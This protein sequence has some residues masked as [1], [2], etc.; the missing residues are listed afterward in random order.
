M[1]RVLFLIMLL[2][3]VLTGCNN[4][5]PT[6][7][8]RFSQYI[9][10]WNE[11]KFEK[12]YG[13][14]STSTKK[15]ISKE[16]F[17]SRYEK[18]YTDL[19][20]G[21]L[22]VQLTKTDQKKEDQKDKEKIDLP[23]TAK[24][25]SIAGE[26]QFD[27]K[28]SLVKEERD[29][30][31]NWYL[32]WNTAF[33]FPNLQDKDKVRL[34]SQPA[35]RGEIID[36]NGNPLAINGFVNEIGIV[37]KDMGD[38]KDQVVQQ[39]AGIL[40]ISPEQINNKLNASWVKPEYFVPL[41]KVSKENQE[42]LQA[43]V[44]LP[45]VQKK[46]AGARIYPYGEATGH[47]IG[48]VGSI[49]AEEL[50]KQKGKGYTS[51]DLIGK[52]GLEQ[53]FEERLRGQSGVQIVIQKEDGTKSVVAEKKVQNGEN[54]ELTIDADLQRS[55]YEQLTGEAG[56]AAAMNPTTGE[57]LALVSS[58]SYDPNQVILG[59]SDKQQEEIKNN[60][61]DPFLNRFK[62]TFAPGSV[63]KPIV[64]SVGLLDGVLDPNSGKN[65]SG[66]KWQ[67]DKSWGGYFVTR[68]HSSNGPVNLEKAL[69]FSDNIYF[70]QTAL[71]IGKDKFSDGLKKF[72]FGEEM[73]YPYPVEASQTG[74]LDSDIHLADSGYGQGQIEMSILHLA[75][76]YT[77]FVNKGNM[78][79][80]TLLMDQP[81]EEVWKPNLLSE[82]QAQ[83]INNDLVQVIEDPSGTAHSGR[84]NGIKLAGKT[85]TAELKVK[86]GEKGKENG[87]FVAYKVDQPDLLIAMM[88]EGV[89]DRGG[90]SFV[91][92]K[93]KNI[94]E[95]Q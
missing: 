40:E 15:N 59:L 53:V 24:M 20:I 36:R 83:L 93:V 18:L 29:K 88:I 85:G 3:I 34:I 17:V 45:G 55:M 67:K 10:L 23:F 42:V 26:I 60:P 86:Q 77:T 75:D 54:I 6:P 46:D 57:T 38:A 56:T 39:L 71:D 8:E 90:S 11:Q 58:P 82:E 25:N 16:D 1:K 4:D 84:I 63:M 41:K 5:E 48:Y 79:K 65:I 72:G 68:V 12:M 21:Q 35:E 94:F 19:E 78:I 87:S 92:K 76:A 30:K 95:N 50:E 2:L 47:V 89:Q 70:A 22:D 14:L 62:M 51:A 9:K 64:A 69:V 80:P 27:H 28:A 91:V 7:E 49:T 33:I 52:R 43:A 66:L 37:P 61:N 31:E 81:K 13:Y 73:N 74:A 32:N 44:P